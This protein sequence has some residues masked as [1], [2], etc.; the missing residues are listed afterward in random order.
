MTKKLKV[1]KD[2]RGSLISY[3][4]DLFK[5][6]RVF[7]INGKKNVIRGN[8]A[9]KNTIQLL[10]NI[11]SKS[12]ISLK[13]N[14]KKNIIFSK[15]GDYV[16][17]PKKTWLKIKFIKEGSIMVICDKKYKKSDYINDIEKFEKLN[18]F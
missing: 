18:P 4:K 2:R 13:N 12:K 3:E 8:H 6:K 11:S 1:I 5:I 14:K 7:V 15:M 9:H 16:I 17:C 10:V